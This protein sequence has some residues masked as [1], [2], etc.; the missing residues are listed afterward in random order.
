MEISWVSAIYARKS[1][2][3]LD[4]PDNKLCF[5]KVGIMFFPEEKTRK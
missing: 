1:A 4:L 3:L 2:S 5:Q